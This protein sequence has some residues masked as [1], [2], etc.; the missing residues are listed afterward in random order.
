MGGAPGIQGRF[1]QEAPG[2]QHDPKGS[3]HKEQKQPEEGET[4]GDPGIYDDGVKGYKDPSWLV[5]LY[6]DIFYV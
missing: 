2:P 1:P 5:K 3:D 6:N 4:V